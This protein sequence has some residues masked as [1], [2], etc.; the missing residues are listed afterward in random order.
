M[1]PFN[2][3][4]TSLEILEKI[5]FVYLQSVPHMLDAYGSLVTQTCDLALGVIVVMKLGLSV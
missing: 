5:P 2:I 1:P 4:T 3:R